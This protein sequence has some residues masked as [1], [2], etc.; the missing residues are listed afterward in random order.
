[1]LTGVE[2][3]VALIE[4]AWVRVGRPR[5]PG[6]VLPF[7][8]RAVGVAGVRGVALGAGLVTAGGE[9]GCLGV[10]G[11]CRR[12]AGTYL[13]DVAAGAVRRAT[14]RARVACRVLTC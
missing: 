8:A 6:R 11:T 14:D 1:M 3:A 13:L 2:G 9:L 12:R 4:R 5:G 10:A 7:A